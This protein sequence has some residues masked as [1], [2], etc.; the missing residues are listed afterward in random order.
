M[1][2]NCSRSER[3]KLTQSVTPTVHA[4]VKTKYRKKG[5]PLY[6]D[7][8]TFNKQALTFLFFFKITSCLNGTPLL[9][10]AKY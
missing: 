9:L 7:I 5:V 1:L 4:S 6:F 10:H 3:C 2:Q 8:T